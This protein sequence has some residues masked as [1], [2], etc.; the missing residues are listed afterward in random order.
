MIIHQL[1]VIFF[2]HLAPSGNLAPCEVPE[3]VAFAFLAHVR[4]HVALHAAWVMGAWE[5]SDG[6]RVANRGGPGWGGEVYGWDVFFSGRLDG[7][8]M[9]K[10]VKPDVSRCLNGCLVVHSIGLLI[11]HGKLEGLDF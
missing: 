3:S 7:G 5:E 9:W 8:N 6:K 11:K 1:I 4:P 10:L 2:P